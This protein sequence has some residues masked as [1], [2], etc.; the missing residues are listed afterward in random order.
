MKYTDTRVQYT[1]M[2]LQ[3]A[4]LVLLQNKPIAKITVKELCETAQINRGTFYL[5]YDSPD[6]L[7][8]EMEEQ[9]LEKS[10]EWWLYYPHKKQKQRRDLVQEWMKYIRENARLYCALMG[11]NGHAEF[12]LRVFRKFQDFSYILYGIESSESNE[13]EM[14]FLADYVYAGGNALILKWLRGDIALSAEEFSRRLS[15]LGY[16]CTKALKEF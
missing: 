3:N 4:M 5:H 7:L 16:Y 9:L 6:A 13:E 12:Q 11:P 8:E 14:K 10:N 1:C 2:S 15:V